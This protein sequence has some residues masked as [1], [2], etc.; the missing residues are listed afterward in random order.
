MS[1]LVL[2]FLVALAALVCT[3][4]RAEEIAL[5]HRFGETRLEPGAALRVVSV[6]YHEQDFLYALGIAPAGVHEWFG[7]RPYAT[8]PWAE[9]ARVALGAEPEVQKGL[10]IDLEW[11]WSMEPDL[12]VA[13]FAPL[14]AR[15]YAQL[16]QIAPVVGPPA[17]HPLW[18]APWTEEL[19][20]IARATGREAQAEAIIAGLDARIAAA[21]TAHPEFRGRS[22]T[23]AYF[24]D[25]LIF[26]YPRH[27][28]ANRLLGAL[29]LATPEGFDALSG[30]EG[31][32]SVSPERLDL[33]DLDVVL[34]QVD[35]P[36]RAAIEALPSWQASRMAREGRAVWAG[37]T[38]TG[39]M[40]F[41]SPLSIGW[42]LERMTPLLS[43][44]LDGDPATGAED[45][46]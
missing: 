37:R 29:G 11:V 19:R 44:A 14:D 23:T 28:G 34:W 38:L 30:D 24:Q 17:D 2:P 41:Q 40:S 22:G 5:R 12:I 46:D 9:A 43:A 32:F 25:G 36:S 16:A 35:A 3:A 31:R 39:A 26:G 33:F 42:A 1:R 27:D 10:E 21:A 4:A 7:D 18:G 13:T 45:R 8:W 20:L 15:T 6:G